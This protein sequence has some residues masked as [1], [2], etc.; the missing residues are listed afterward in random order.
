MDFVDDVD[1]VFCLIGLESRS[2]DE[3]TDILYSVIARTIDLD[4]IEE[5]IIV[6][7]STVR[8]YVTGVS[9]LWIETVQSL[10]EYA[11]TCRLPGPT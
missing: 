8:T 11:R 3:I 5:S 10:R 9:I 2:L 6:E 7:C 1:F 4:D